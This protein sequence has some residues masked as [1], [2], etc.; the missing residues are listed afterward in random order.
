MGNMLRLEH[1]NGGSG[2]TREFTVETGNNR[3]QQLK[4]S[5][6]TYAYVFDANGNMRS[7]TVSRH[8]EWNYADQMKTFR[9]Q[10]EVAEPSV[11]AH[12][13]YDAAG[14]RVKKLVRKQGGQVEV[15]HY[16]DG[17][18]EHHRWSNGAQAGE[19]NHVHVVD[20]T[21]RIALVRFGA[22]HP[23]DGGPAA[24]FHLGDHL[25][26][27]NVVVDA[28]GA[29]TNR[30][31]F[32]PYGETSFGSFAKKRYRFTGME[33]DEE[34]GLNYHGAR[35]YAQWLARWVSCDPV[36][37]DSNGQPVLNRYLGLG[38]NPIKFVDPQG[39]SPEKPPTGIWARIKARGN[40]IIA[41]GRL[42]YDDPDTLPKSD[43]KR[44]IVAEKLR[45][46]GDEKATRLGGK[47]RPT[48]GVRPPPPEPP[49]GTRLLTKE[50]LI[51]HRNLGNAKPVSPITPAGGGTG[52]TGGAGGGHPTSGVGGL[53]SGGGGSPPG[54]SS[55]PGLPPGPP[56]SRMGS[57][58]RQGLRFLSSDLGFV[59]TLTVGTIL[60]SRDPALRSFSQSIGERAEEFIGSD[61]V[62]AITAAYVHTQ[63][64]AYKAATAAV[65]QPVKNTVNAYKEA[66]AKT[67]VKHVALGPIGWIGTLSGLF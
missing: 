54:G 59:V 17:A 20:D 49:Q 16:I 19:N 11:H 65:V 26:S 7:E 43:P 34:S 13:L 8:F 56:P 22:A 42:L 32:T 57:V 66:P 4:I 48:Q 39:K 27:S 6:N 63:L 3:L 38:L 12:Y 45:D 31:E 53:T 40:E 37:V 50:D 9:T 24:Q 2:F 25:G 14:Q 36:R 30:E 64:S 1:C 41:A 23:E 60:E 67:L 61:V 5:G 21:R 46:I 58:F 35:Y 55:S 62:G 52:G 47:N 51:K 29:W 10:T 15:T 44:D 33:R 28:A 18:F